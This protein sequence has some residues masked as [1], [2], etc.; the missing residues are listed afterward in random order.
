MKLDLQ[1]KFKLGKARGKLIY[2]AVVNFM[3][4]EMH[5]GQI[6]VAVEI[7]KENTWKLSS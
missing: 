4:M 3:A 5:T 1:G 7:V 6:K 2:Q